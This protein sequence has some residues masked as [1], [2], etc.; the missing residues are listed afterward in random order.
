MGNGVIGKGLQKRKTEANQYRTGE[1]EGQTPRFDKASIG[2]I[3][4]I[5]LKL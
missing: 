1:F 5:Y 3:I 4:F 2:H